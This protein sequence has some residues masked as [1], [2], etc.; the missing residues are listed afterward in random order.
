[1]QY[2]SEMVLLFR[3]RKLGVVP[4][5]NYVGLIMHVYQKV[6]RIVFTAL[7]QVFPQLL[8]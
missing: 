7:L 1:M 2:N 3:G 5:C 4:F 8:F 6:T